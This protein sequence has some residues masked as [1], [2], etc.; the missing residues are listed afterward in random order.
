MVCKHRVP[1]SSPQGISLYK[2][3]LVLKGIFR[4]SEVHIEQEIFPSACKVEMKRHHVPAT[5]PEGAGPWQHGPATRPADR[6]SAKS[7][8]SGCWTDGVRRCPV[9]GVRD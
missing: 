3:F 5:L 9:M 2:T 7:L 6:T 8:P 1:L 4:A